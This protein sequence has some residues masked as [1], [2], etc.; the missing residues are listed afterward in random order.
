[1]WNPATVYIPAN[2]RERYLTV[3][4]VAALIG[5][6]PRA[7]YNLNYRGAGPIPYP[8][9]RRVLYYGREVEEWIRQNSCEKGSS[10]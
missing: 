7:V 1:M 3:E 4:Q 5:R 9:G 10:G 8:N 2:W 6:T